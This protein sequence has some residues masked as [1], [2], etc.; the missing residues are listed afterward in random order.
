MDP[1]S[2]LA[3]RPLDPTLDKPLYQQ[4][5]ERILQLIATGAVDTET[6]LPTEASLCR[7]LGLSRSTVRRCFADLVERGYVVRRRG[8]G[9]FLSGRSSTGH[10]ESIYT[11]YNST[12][13]IERSGRHASA[14]VLRLRRLAASEA[15]ARA[16]QIGQ[17]DPVWEIRRLRLA[18]DVPLRY[19]ISC[20]PWELCPG[21]TVDRIEHS[22][23]ACLMEDS[24]ILP[25]RADMT[26]EAVTLDE[27]EAK[28]LEVAAGSAAFRVRS[29]SIAENGR[30]IERTVSL[31]P[32]SGTHLSV[33]YDERGAHFRIET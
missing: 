18:D 16:L 33:T 30:P 13:Q 28:I 4:L 6:P 11:L 3:A 25:Y 26:L 8:L 14:R 29:L 12:T 17:G 10:G 32:A 23:Y 9:T 22:L 31:W 20:V 2:V 7:A 15:I 27:R 21:L 19:E 5:K 1:L 24:G